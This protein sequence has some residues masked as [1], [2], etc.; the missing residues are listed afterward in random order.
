MIMSD[1]M[2][3]GISIVAVGTLAGL[4]GTLADMTNKVGF[5]WFLVF[6]IIGAGGAGVYTEKQREEAYKAEQKRSEEALRMAA[7]SGRLV[8]EGLL[9]NEVE[10]QAAENEKAKLISD[11]QKL[12]E[13][14]RS[15][16]VSVV[17]IPSKLE[18]LEDA[19]AKARKKPIAE[20]GQSLRTDI[21]RGFFNIA[22]P[23]ISL[24][25]LEVAKIEKTLDSGKPLKSKDLELI[26][27]KL[28]EQLERNPLENSL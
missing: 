14:T 28:A 26:Q 20:M 12:V 8:E 22:K 23:N 3:V 17:A 21:S 6:V 25:P 5:K 19:A 15:L 1:T 2:L 11:R 18:E 10:R 24:G 13:I 27:T 4:I 16:T 7:E 9:K